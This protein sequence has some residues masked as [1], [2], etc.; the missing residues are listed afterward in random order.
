MGNCPWCGCRMDVIEEG[1]QCPSCGNFFE[2]E[3]EEVEGDDNN[4]E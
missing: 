1:P 2:G 3:I 4:E